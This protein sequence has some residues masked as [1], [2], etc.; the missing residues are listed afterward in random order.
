MAV[1]SRR[2][3]SVLPSSARR[4]SAPSKRTV[5]SPARRRRGGS[6]A[7]SRPYV[8]QVSGGIRGPADMSTVSFPCLFVQGA[9]RQAADEVPLDQEAER[10]RWH[11][12]DDGERARLPVLGA[13]EAQ[14]RAKD[15]GERERGPAGQD[16][17]E[18]E[19]RPCVN[20]REHRRGDDPG[21]RQGDGDHFQHL[22]AAAS[23][24]P[25]GVL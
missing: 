2:T 9:E 3:I 6:G 5:T 16:E 11:Q 24:D 15:G 18:E 10:D 13:L 12:R 7:C 25:R 1:Y 4:R 22:P 19:F 14:K 17:G 23:I 8:N 20:E 21:G